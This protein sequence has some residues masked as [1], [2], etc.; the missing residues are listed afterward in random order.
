[1]KVSIIGALG[2]GLLL[3][4]GAG[5]AQA[6]L[7]GELPLTVG[8]TD[9]QAYYDPV[10]NLTWLANANAAGGM[11][12]WAAATSWVSGLNIGGV[13]GWRLPTADAACGPYYGCVGSEMG[14]LFYNVLGG[15]AGSNIATVHN[16]NYSLFSNI[17]SG[18]YW[19]STD[20]SPTQKWNFH[21]DNGLQYAE[22]A[23]N[24]QFVWAVYSGNA[25]PVPLPAAAWL[26]GSGLLG[27]FGA[28]R[29]RKV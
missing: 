6:A 4:M 27:L 18:A 29:R 5:Q 9:Y 23:A 16:S 17:Q 24:S 20:F 19:T 8:G 14:N 22:L 2:A 1:M 13:T 28:A 15:V 12:T 25:A 7:I 26:L 10:A 21:M 11:M 3:N